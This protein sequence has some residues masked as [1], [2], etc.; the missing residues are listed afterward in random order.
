[1]QTKLTK[2]VVQFY[3]FSSISYAINNILDSKHE[4]EIN[5][6]LTCKIHAS[7]LHQWKDNFTSSLSK[8]IFGIFRAVHN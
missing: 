8:F 1:M 7:Q 2:A 4:I 6:W 3:H 5:P